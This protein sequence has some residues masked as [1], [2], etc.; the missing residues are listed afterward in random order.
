[1]N[2]TNHNLLERENNFDFLRLLF[3]SLVIFSHSFPLTGK[4]EPFNLLTN[5][6]IDLGGLSVN[7]F[8]II[9]GY[10]IMISLKNC[11]SIINYFWKRCL[12]LFPGLFV[13]LC[14]SLIVLIV[15]YNGPNIF[16]EKKFY[17][18]LPR[19]LFLY[20]VQY[21]VKGVFEHNIYP[22][23]INGSLW[24]LCYEFSMYLCIGILFPLKKQL[25]KLL[26]VLIIVW[27]LSYFL[28]LNKANYFDF[29]FNKLFLDS[30]QFFRL[31]LYFIAGSILSFVDLKKYNKK[32]IKIFLFITLLISVFLDKFHLV[33]YTLLPIFVL[34]IGISYSKPL[35][36]IPHRIGDISYGVYIYGFLVQQTLMNYFDLNSISLA[37][38]SLL[39]T[40]L[41]AY[42]SWY[43]IEKKMLKFKNI[44]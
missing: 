25:K 42:L 44:I 43:L 11:K 34:L 41:L 20:K 33:S 36:Y 27:L 2:F 17:S 16:M 30:N 3:S 29:L 5:G 31:S 1:M 9:S 18:Y 39:C 14:I 21:S 23:A 4:R 40:Y 7:I 35:N 26:F 19:N 22:R 8:F 10:L 6:Q 37:I 24:S 13:M 38:L 28:F 32:N 15:V 12:R